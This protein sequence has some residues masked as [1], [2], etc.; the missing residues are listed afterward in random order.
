MAYRKTYEMIGWAYEA[1]H[2]CPAC[3][4]KRF[5]ELKADMNAQVFDNEGNEV[6]AILLGDEFDTTPCCDDCLELLDV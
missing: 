5:P 4:Y 2:H 3:T 6:T 1:G